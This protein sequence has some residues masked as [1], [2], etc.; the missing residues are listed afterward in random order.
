[1]GWRI[2]VI[3]QTTEIMGYE[4]SAVKLSKGLGSTC[5]AGGGRGKL[6]RGA[7]K[8]WCMNFTIRGSS[9]GGKG[10]GKGRGNGRL[11]N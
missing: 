4:F 5:D 1:M 8:E 11:V 7:W 10:A 2:W 6:G 3:W 9:D